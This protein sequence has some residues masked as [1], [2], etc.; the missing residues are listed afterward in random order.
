MDYKSGLYDMCPVLQIVLKLIFVVL[1]EF[2]RP[3][4][5]IDVFVMSLI[6]IYLISIHFFIFN[7]Y[8]FL[9]T[10]V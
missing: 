5:Q 2:Y 3:Y 1:T 6:K 8:I 7:K 4:R 9:W 10:K